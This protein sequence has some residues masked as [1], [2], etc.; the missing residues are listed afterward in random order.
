L[1]SVAMVIENI[2]EK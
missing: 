1:G 2:F